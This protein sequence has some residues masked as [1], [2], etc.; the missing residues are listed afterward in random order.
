[1]KR[2]GILVIK[3]PFMFYKYDLAGLKVMEFSVAFYYDV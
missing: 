1:M 2:E 3:M